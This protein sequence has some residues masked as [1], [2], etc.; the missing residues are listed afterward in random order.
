M[1]SRVLVVDDIA[2]NVRLLETK[3]QAEYLDV[4]TASGGREALDV[5]NRERID[6]VLLDVMMPDMTGFEV[7]AALK[8]NPR[9]AHVPVIIVTSLDQIEDRVKGLESGADDFLTKPV[10]E[11]ALTARVKSLLRLKM[12]TDELELRAT[13]MQSVGLDPAVSI[14]SNKAV[15]GRVLVVDDRENSTVR[16]RQAL[17]RPFEVVITDDPVD[18]RKLAEEREFDLIMISLSL[19]GGDGLRLCT[20]IKTIDRLRQ[21]PVLLIT[22]AN[23]TP[24]V[25]RALDLGVND[26]I[27]RPIDA[28]ELR[29][30]VRTQLRRK[31]YQDSL[32]S[33]VTQAVEFAITDALTS[34]YN[35]RYLDAHLRTAFSSAERTGKPLCVLVFDI[36]HFKGI[37]DTYGHDAGDDVLRGFAERL[38][39]GVRGIDLV[40]R[41]G[42]EEFV[43]VMPDTD[44]DYA[45]G[46][47]E[48]LRIDVERVPF[49]TNSGVQI[50]VTVS[51]GI[52][53]WQGSSDTPD[54]IIKRADRALFSAK[55]SGRNRVVASAA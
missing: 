48:R 41:Y 32:R 47:A 38:R 13:A 25:V 14:D 44:A 30:R 49:E 6:L 12:V 53:Q 28:N 11:V 20:Q 35:R 42:G 21:T 26:Y 55:R 19:K 3:L 1:T 45:A 29:A 27:I 5:L 18:A 22:D 36:D 7:C 8:S 34:L 16:I 52:A 54:A 15:A 10:S 46:V 50:P 23:E 24:M 2:A 33:M 39:N 37:N 4:R 43:L 9:T 31:F 40:S 51:I 17:Q